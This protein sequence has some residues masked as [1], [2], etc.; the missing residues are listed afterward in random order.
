MKHLAY[1]SLTHRWTPLLLL[2]TLMLAGCLQQ[3]PAE[4]RADYLSTA[5]EI[6]LGLVWPVNHPKATLLDG[7]QLAVEEINANGGLLG[8][9]VRLELRDDDRSVDQAMIIAQELSKLPQLS[10]VIAHLDTSLAVASAPAYQF[11]EML[12]LSPGATGM[13]L[14]DNNYPYIF[15]SMVNIAQ[16]SEQLADFMHER[17]H[18]NVMVYYIDNAFGRDSAK[19]FEERATEIGMNIVDRRGYAQIGANHRLVLNEWNDFFSFDA[20]YLAGSLPEGAGIIQEIRNLGIPVPIYGGVGLDSEAL[21][22]LGGTSA[23]GV[24]V[25]SPFHPDMPLETAREFVETYQ[26]AFGV[27]PD[28]SAAGGYDAV[29]L[30]AEAITRSG[31]IEPKAIA[32]ALHG[33]TDWPGVTGSHTFGE[34]GDLIDKRIIFTVVKDGKFEFLSGF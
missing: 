12:M 2:A 14:T 1:F 22:S 9:P 27:N 6:T 17:G 29:Y 25:T 20:V 11:E 16:S 30:I 13:A 23:E 32:E 10:A 33:I 7:A 19:F 21:I 31:S 4:T 34:N 18:A 28:A 8:K 5:E 15:R 26:Q 24:V 3:D